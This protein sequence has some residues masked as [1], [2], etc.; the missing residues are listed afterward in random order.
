MALPKHE[1]KAIT[2]VASPATSLATLENQGA[3]AVL[4]CTNANVYFTV[5]SVTTPIITGA[6]EVGTLLRSTDLGIILTPEEFVNS[7]WVS[8]SGTARVQFAF[9]SGDRHRIY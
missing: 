5:D 6:S 9:L 1:T 3:G 8:V 4:V 2:S 7:K